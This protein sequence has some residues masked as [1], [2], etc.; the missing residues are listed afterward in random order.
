MKPQ[1][2]EHVHFSR[3]NCEKLEEAL[4]AKEADLDSKE[5][6]L[7]DLSKTCLNQRVV[8]A[9]AASL[10]E[11]RAQLKL[12]WASIVEVPVV[13]QYIKQVFDI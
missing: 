9:I 2:V 6:Q 5:L 10:V 1:N 11:E 7:I 8:D 13:R 4:L 12:R 3:S